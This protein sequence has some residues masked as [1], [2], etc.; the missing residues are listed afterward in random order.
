MELLTEFRRELLKSIE[1]LDKDEFY[2]KAEIS[3]IIKQCYTKAKSRCD[4][5]EILASDES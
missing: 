2:T 4:E 5:Q 1:Q 3:T